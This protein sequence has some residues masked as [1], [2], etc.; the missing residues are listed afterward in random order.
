MAKKTNPNDRNAAALAERKA[1]KGTFVANDGRVIKLKPKPN[2]VFIQQAINSVEFPTRPTY[3]VTI[4]KR[5]QEYPLDREAIDQTADPQEK[6]RLRKA[7]AKYLIDLNQASQLQAR[8]GSGATIYEGT[9]VDD[10]MVESDTKWLKKMRIT[11]WTIPNDSEERWVFY[12]QT[13]LD[14]D[15][16]AKLGARVVQQTGGAT[17]EEIEAA[18]EMFRDD[19]SDEPERSGDVGDVEGDEGADTAG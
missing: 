12:L 16:L 5:V 17:E 4:G 1:A 2:L 7:W 11:G 18:M 15:E 8:R 6:A 13:S 14:D 9:Q 10:E 3:E 19:I